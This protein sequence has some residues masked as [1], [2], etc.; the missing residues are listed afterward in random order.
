MVHGLRWLPSGLLIPIIVLL[1]TSRGYSLAEYGLLATMIGVTTFVLE[2]PTG[3]LADALG[4]R[5][6]LLVS[7][8]F[9]FVSTALLVVVAW[10][11]SRPSF[12][13]VLVAMIAFGVYR[14]L[15]SGP[16][17]A[18]YVDA[19][20]AI[21]PGADV[22]AG[23]GRAGTVTGASIAVGSLAAGGLL[24]WDPFPSIDPMAVVLLVS[25]ALVV[26]QAISLVAVMHDPRPPLGLGA[27]RTAVRD[28]PHVVRS[29]L[30]LATTNRVLG[31]LLGTEATWAVGMVA[32]ENLFP[33]RLEALAGSPD[34]AAAMLGPASAAAWAASGA[35]A[36]VVVHLSR[37]L[38]PYR[39]AAL[40]RLLQGGTIL[41][42]GMLAG[43]PGAIGGLIATYLVHG[44]S[45]PVHHAL[46]HRQV[47]ASRRATVL[48]LNSMVF[49]ASI[50]VAAVV[51]G[52]LADAWTVPA[53]IAVCAAVTGA[54]FVLP[55]LARRHDPDP[56]RVRID[57]D[58]GDGDDTSLHAGRVHSR[59]DS[60]RHAPPSGA[61][62]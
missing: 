24:A 28:V 54:G 13:L 16:L 29:T 25:L 9:S 26:A 61:D 33:V 55:L 56:R 17:D 21:D 40:L 34:A 6:V 19:A 39:T 42:M 18:W 48:S 23:L 14:A 2:L 10:S 20:H 4:R 52:A 49:F 41:A 50:S 15:E 57:G 32:F 58:D 22:E 5:R 51:L 31:W 47:D 62:R 43:V 8:A 59:T 45:A 60:G 27:V 46:L 30:S 12:P 7:V 35:G 36:G 1:F 3:G 38:G 11:P 37:A 44:A 53:A